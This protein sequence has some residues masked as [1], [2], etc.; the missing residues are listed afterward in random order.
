MNR[1]SISD[2]EDHVGYWL[3][4]VSNH[5]SQAFTAKV[6]AQG[7]TVAEWVLLREMFDHSAA[8]P[9]QLADRLA[10]SRGAVSKLIDRLVAKDLVEK[11]I[12][13]EFSSNQDGRYQTVELT[14][15]GRKLVPKLANLA[16][17]NDAEFF[18]HMTKSEKKELMRLLKEI[19]KK[20]SWKELPTS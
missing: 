8:N 20:H 19:V 9:S 14:T 7:V 11:R 10:L 15:A 17:K 16:D 5:V 6:E 1:G 2:L 12:G 18:D 13:S 4:F 3:R